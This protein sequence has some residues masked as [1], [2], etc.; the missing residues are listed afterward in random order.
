MILRE[1]VAGCEGRGEGVQSVVRALGLLE[2]VAQMGDAGVTAIARAA[3]LHVATTHN[4]LRTLATLGY[5]VNIGGRYRLGPAVQQLS[6]HWSPASALPVLVGPA[7]HRVSEQTGETGSLGLLVGDQCLVI[8]VSRGTSDIVA[9]LQRRMFDP[10]SVATGRLLAAMSDPATRQRMVSH[11]LA[12]AAAG[13]EVRWQ[14]E[15]ALIADDRC[16]VV[17][18]AYEGGADAVA[19]LQRGRGG[20]VLGALGASC[21]HFRGSEDHLTDMVLALANAADELA[22]QSGG[23]P[24]R[25]SNEHWRAAVRRQMRAAL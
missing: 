2:Q 23:T 1:R 7:M 10:L 14:E 13:D 9:Q 20:I 3:G 6:A 4:L 17:C 11:H 25:L 18:R 24:Q 15:L 8:P 19:V 12:T 21:P 5:L 16:A 22:E